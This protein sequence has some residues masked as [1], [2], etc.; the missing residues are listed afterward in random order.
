[1]YW[2][3]AQLQPNHER[4]AW[5]CLRIAGFTVYAPRMRAPRH[6]LQQKP[7]A[8]FPGYCFVQ[9]VLQWHA[10]RYCPGVVRLVGD[11]GGPSHVPDGVIA[12]LR[13][14]ER[15]GLVVLPERGRIRRGA[16]VKILRGPF[17]GMPAIFADTKSRERVEILLA[18]LNSQ[19]RL[20]L[21]KEDVEAVR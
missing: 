20:I 14:H 13:R 3:C 2:T 11:G 18:L 15:N 1:M 12:E 17:E 16:A 6:A 8:L 21:P 10:A 7:R 5:H 9:I 4:L 19:V